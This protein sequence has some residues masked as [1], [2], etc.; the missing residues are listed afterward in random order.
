MSTLEKSITVFCTAVGR[1]NSTI[2]RSRRQWNPI[3][4]NEMRMSPDWRSKRIMT[5]SA[6]IPWD[7]MVA[8]AAP[9]TPM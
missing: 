1:P 8:M 3:L 7:T 4:R 5:S 6:A 2:S 9:S